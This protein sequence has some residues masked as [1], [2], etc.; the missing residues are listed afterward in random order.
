MVNLQF[1]VNSEKYPNKDVSVGQVAIILE[2]GTDKIPPV[3]VF[4]MGLEKSVQKHKKLIDA[5]L[6]NISNHLLTGR[7]DSLK[8]NL[9]QVMTQIGRSATKETKDLIKSGTLTP[10]NAQSTI[11]RKGFDHRDWETGLLHDSVAYEVSED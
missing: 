6:K 2:Q 4:R 5:A 11:D 10:G 7:K 3:P 9:L 8:R 1:G